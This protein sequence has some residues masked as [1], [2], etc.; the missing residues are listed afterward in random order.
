MLLLQTSHKVSSCLPV[1]PAA[2]G[3]APV[4][5]VLLR[6]GD[7]AAGHAERDGRRG[8]RCRRRLRTG[9]EMQP[10]CNMP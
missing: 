5:C 8:L 1:Q 10:L 6:A 2:D 3:A 9:L 7:V 4:A